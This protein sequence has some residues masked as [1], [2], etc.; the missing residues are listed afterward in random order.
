MAPQARA[1]QL[2]YALTG[3]GFEEGEL[4][5]DFDAN[6]DGVAGDLTVVSARLAS[7]GDALPPILLHDSVGALAGGSASLTGNSLKWHELPAYSHTFTTYCSPG[8]EAL[9]LF[10]EPIGGWPEV[11]VFDES[12]GMTL[13]LFDRATG[14]PIAMWSFSSD[15]RE[16]RE[17]GMSFGHGG[18]GLSEYLISGHA[19]PEP[20]V[21]ALAVLSSL[22]LGFARARSSTRRG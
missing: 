17:F 22:S 7:T 10:I 11:Q 9:C 16:L 8:Q 20:G 1:I 18:E 6:A 12:G 21:S 19:I 14:D 13:S 3:T 4:T 2:T 5:L 15:L